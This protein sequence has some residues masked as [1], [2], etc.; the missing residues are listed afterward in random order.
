MP[1]RVASTFR[2]YTVTGLPGALELGD[3]LSAQG[4]LMSIGHSDADYEQVQEAVRHGYKLVTHLHS[5]MSSLH[6]VRALRVLGVVESAYLMDELDVEIIADGLH[7]PPELLLSHE[8][9]MS[10]DTPL[11]RLCDA[12]WM[13]PPD[14]ALTSRGVAAE[15]EEA[16]RLGLPIRYVD[17]SEFAK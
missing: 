9:W 10:Q 12:I 15:V 17:E 11:L 16:T 7:L 13:C 14:A 3:T 2:A 1:L 4:V 5:G 8:F 6:R